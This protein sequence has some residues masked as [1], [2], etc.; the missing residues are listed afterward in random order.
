MANCLVILR[1]PYQAPP[2]GTTPVL[3]AVIVPLENIT[4]PAHVTVAKASFA[5]QCVKVKATV[6]ATIENAL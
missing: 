3:Y 6:V 5:G 1:R 4:G 2:P